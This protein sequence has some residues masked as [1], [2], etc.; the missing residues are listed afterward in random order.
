MRNMGKLFRIYISCMEWSS[1]TIM[2]FQS[3][4]RLWKSGVCEWEVLP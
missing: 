2:A 3:V 4:Q 1:N